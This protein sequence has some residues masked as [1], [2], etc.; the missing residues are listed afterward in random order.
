M[1][2]CFVIPG[3]KF[4]TALP[5]EAQPIV[6]NAQNAKMIAGIL[7]MFS[8]CDIDRFALNLA[9]FQYTLRHSCASIDFV[10]FPVCTDC[11]T[12]RLSSYSFAPDTS[13]SEPTS[14]SR[15]STTLPTQSPNSAPVRSWSQ[16]SS[17]SR[18]SWSPAS[19]CRRRR[20]CSISLTPAVKR[21]KAARIFSPGV[22]PPLSHLAPET[23]SAAR[24]NLGR[25]RS[26]TAV[27]DQVE[28]PAFERFS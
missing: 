23:T 17:R 16:A 24:L 28:L 4:T 11:I 15:H 8:P 6:M 1:T 13:E 14:R 25:G 3:S 7:V 22:M 18:I 20:F 2:C 21:S 19:G 5:V 10:H 12:D 26:A 27:K 9:S